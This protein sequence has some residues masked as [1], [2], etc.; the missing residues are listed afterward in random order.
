M[1]DTQPEIVYPGIWRFKNA[2]K[3]SEAAIKHYDENLN[4]EDWYTFGNNCGIGSIIAQFE[5]FPT[6]QEWQERIISNTTDPFAKEIQQ[7]YYEATSQYIK[8]HGITVDGD[9]DFQRMDIARYFVDKSIDPVNGYAM[10]YHTDNQQELTDRPGSKFRVTCIFYL[11]DD[12]EGGDISF[13]VLSQ[14]GKTLLHEESFKPTAGDIFVFP[15]IHPYYHGVKTVFGSGARSKYIIRSYWRWLSDGSEFYKEFM[16]THTQE[17]WLAFDE[18]RIEDGRQKRF[19]NVM[20][21]E[22]FSKKDWGW[23]PNVLS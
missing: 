23:N 3:N 7:L 13:K 22:D 20:D 4:W 6:E 9:W 5:T 16:K 17:E 21:G 15:S 11:N 14:D 10:N 19:F 2:Y 8:H 1:L 18:P 12:Y